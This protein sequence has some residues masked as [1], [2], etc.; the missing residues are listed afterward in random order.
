MREKE[1]AIETVCP[2]EDVFPTSILT[3]QFHL[4]VHLVYKV[5][6]VGTVHA[7]WIFFLERFMKNL[8]GFLRQ[9]AQPKGSMAEGWLV[10][11]S[12]FFVVD[13]LSR[14]Q[15]NVSELW[16]TRDNDRLLSDVP[17][18][19]GVVKQLSKEIRTKVSNYCMMN[20]DV[21]Q[22]WYEM[23]ERTRQEQMHA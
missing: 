10:Q 16:S 3:I 12:C 19:N 11:K 18:S 8:K 9:R 15:K 4:L 7:R 5:E 22:R 23:Y 1:N 21:M 20:N 6:I 14:S 17:P 13:Y 2:F